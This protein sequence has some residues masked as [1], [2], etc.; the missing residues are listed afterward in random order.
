MSE[1]LRGKECLQ[2]PG[3]R[4]NRAVVGRIRI[5][6]LRSRIIDD[7]ECH[8]LLNVVDGYCVVRS[9]PKFQPIYA[10]H[11]G[12]QIDGKIDTVFARFGADEGLG[13]WLRLHDHAEISIDKSTEMNTGLLVPSHTISH[14]HSSSRFGCAPR[15]HIS[16]LSNQL[17]RLAR[18]VGRVQ[19]DGSV[20]CHSDE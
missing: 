4:D 7:F 10:G 9:D 14:L 1:Q 3:R 6:P 20:A 13:L 15:R 16:I 12:G 11:Q 5:A 17:L 2:G 8:S 18:E 19:V